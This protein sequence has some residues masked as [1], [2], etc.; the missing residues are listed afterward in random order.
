MSYSRWSTSVWYTY[1]SDDGFTICGVKHFTNEE[2]K[3]I[4]ACIQWLKDH[5]ESED[6]LGN[7]ENMTFTDEE[8]EELKGY[9]EKHKSSRWYTVSKEEKEE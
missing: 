2:L 5:P 7:K 6:A 1:P 8:Y 3:D 4:D 9:I